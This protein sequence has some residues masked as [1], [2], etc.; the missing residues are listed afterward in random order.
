MLGWRLG[1]A[2][3]LSAAL[4]VVSWHWLKAPYAFTEATQIAKNFVELLQVGDTQSAY[5]LTLKNALVGATPLEF[6]AISAH[7]LCGSNLVLVGHS[8]VQTNG[9]RFRRWLKATEIDM[10]EIRIEFEQGPCLF[11]VSLRHA[12]NGQWKVYYFQSHAG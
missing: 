2:I 12:V 10:P 3:T 11:E 4:A 7:Q 8:P 9:N 5:Q 1:L 6:K